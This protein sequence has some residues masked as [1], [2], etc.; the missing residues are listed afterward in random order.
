MKN[1][2]SISPREQ[3]ASKKIFFL[4]Q[5]FPLFLSFL[6]TFFRDKF[7]VSHKHMIVQNSKKKYRIFFSVLATVQRSIIGD[8]RKSWS[9]FFRDFLKDFLKWRHAC[10]WSGFSSQLRDLPPVRLGCVRKVV[11]LSSDLLPR[12][13][14]KLHFGVCFALRRRLENAPAPPQRPT[15]SSVSLSFSVPSLCS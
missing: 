15:S 6:L 10:V 9:L 4:P 11:R 7:S 5:H 1:W 3:N 2:K 14:V 8:W 12:P 13:H